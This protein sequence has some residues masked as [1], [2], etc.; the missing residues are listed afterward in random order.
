M[1]WVCSDCGKTF[2]T[3][4]ARQ[5]HIAIYHCEM[6]AYCAK[7]AAGVNHVCFNQPQASEGVFGL[8]EGTGII[9][10]ID[11]YILSV[12]GI[13]LNA[14]EDQEVRIRALTKEQRVNL[15]RI[16]GK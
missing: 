2:G 9:T 1:G 3:G 11:R 6:P 15:L 8:I 4:P 14:T 10:R 12:D 7:C 13:H 16:L 5:F